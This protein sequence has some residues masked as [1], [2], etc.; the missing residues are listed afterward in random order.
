MENYRLHITNKTILPWNQRDRIINQDISDGFGGFTPSN[1]PGVFWY[2][3]LDDD[4]VPD[5]VFIAVGGEARSALT[6]FL[7]AGTDSNELLRQVD[8]WEYYNCF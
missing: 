3:D 6:L 1:M 8:S 5:I 4:Q 7:S 2:G